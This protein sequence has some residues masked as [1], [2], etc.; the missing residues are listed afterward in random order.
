MLKFFVYAILEG[1]CIFRVNN[2]FCQAIPMI[3]Y[4]VGEEML[5]LVFLRALFSD[6]ELVTSKS[7][8]LIK[9]EKTF[10]RRPVVKTVSNFVNLNKVSTEA[11]E[12]KAW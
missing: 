11:S 5:I 10:N 8:A 12:L 4:S 1:V 9:L 7:C 6:F 2:F 3:H